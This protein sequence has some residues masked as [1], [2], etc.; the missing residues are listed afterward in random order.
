VSPVG[1]PEPLFPV[2]PGGVDSFELVGPALHLVRRVAPQALPELEGS[3]CRHLL[4]L[5]HD[6][7]S[8]LPCRRRPPPLRS[9]E[10]I[11]QRI[12]VAFRTPTPERQSNGHI[13]RDCPR[14][15]N[16]FGNLFPGGSKAFYEAG[17]RL[18]GSLNALIDGVPLRHTPRQSGHEDGV[19][20]LVF[21]WLKD[22]GVPAHEA[23]PSQERPKFCRRKPRLVQNRQQSFRLDRLARVHGNRDSPRPFR[24][25]QEYV[26]A[27]LR[28]AKPAGMA[29]SPYD[30]RSG[31]TGE[32]TAHLGLQGPTANFGYCD[33]PCCQGFLLSRLCLNG[34]SLD[35]KH[36]TS[37]GG[38][39]P[40]E[41]TRSLHADVRQSLK[42]A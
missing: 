24:M 28:V 32:S 12:A 38:T 29:K 1:R 25:S 5:A 31:W 27:A 35:S 8:A 40:E 14:G 15:L 16:L 4:S 34:S 26:G 13:D 17:D 23:N 22:Y 10:M 33:T 30:F 37:L 19:A 11:G 39:L 18:L 21:I 7:R 9:P 20:A 41:Q 42:I 3:R 36:A 6:Q 2:G